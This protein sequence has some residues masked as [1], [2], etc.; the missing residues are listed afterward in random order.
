MSGKKN[1]FNWR[2]HFIELLVVIIGI[3]I[4]FT[5]EGWSADRKQQKLQ[6]SYL[7]SLKTDLEKDKEDL[8][9]IIDSTNV[10]IKNVGEMFGFIYQNKP[11]EVYRRHH[12]TSAYLP[13]YFYPQNGTYVSLNNS[14]DI[15][16]VESFELKAA[17]SDLY[18]VQ[19]RALEQMDDVVK[20]LVDNMI[21]PYMINEIEFS[22]TRDGIEDASPLKATK[23]INMLGSYFNIL[24]TRQE[25]YA[26]MMEKCQALI[27]QVDKELGS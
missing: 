27:E 22:F 1:K 20:N 12:I 21:Q 10:I 24:G 8:Q 7:N 4:A 6:T 25:G 9:L 14:G 18:N 11:A 2:L 23:A 13:S 26:E 17:L 5:L 15:S 16:V 3:S 19:Y